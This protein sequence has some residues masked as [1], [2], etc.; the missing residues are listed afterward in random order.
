MTAATLR[1][2]L[3]APRVAAPPGPVPEPLTS[4]PEADLIVGQATVQ[5]GLAGPVV[6]GP[7]TLFA[8]RG[9]HLV[10]PDGPLLVSDTGHHRVLVWDRLPGE[11]GAPAD[12]VL[13][14]ADFQGEG[15]N[16][17]GDPTASGLNVPTGI[18]FGE[19]VLV[20]ADA[21]NH[22]IL[23]WNGLP[24]SGQAADLVLGQADFG[25]GSPNRGSDR[26]GADTLHWPYGVTIHQGRL[27][28]AD[29]GNRRL[30]VWDRIP[31]RNGQPANL[32]LGQTGF[33]CRDENAGLEPGAGG[34]RWPH[35]VAA[36]DDGVL[37]VGDAGDNRIMGWRGLP[38]VSGAPCDFVLGQ[39][40][41]GGVD[42]NRGV[43]RPTA[44]SLNMPYGVAL[45]GGRLVTADTANSR[46]LGYD[47]DA[48]ITGGVAKGLA[49][50]DGFAER[51][52]NRWGVADRAALCW[53]YAVGSCG[54]TLVVADSGNNRV[55]VW[56]AS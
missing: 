33:D 34:M 7:T 17:G 46:L 26:P 2:S 54:G 42:H 8:P 10:A 43:Y 27:L 47:R 19:G 30:L 49:G 35:A 16:D 56:R 3:N 23:L 24:S 52:D 5:A 39:A 38:T 32:V 40:D 20:V 48:W 37:F 55:L 29:T 6:A 11:D 28:V 22:R 9:A 4:R 14:H 15:R 51:G 41:A 25:G 12:R 18:C 13:G 1:V 36:S 21:W 50:Q 44:A 53:P 31:T 45:H